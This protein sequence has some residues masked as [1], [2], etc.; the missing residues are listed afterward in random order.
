MISYKKFCQGLDDFDDWHYTVGG[1]MCAAKG[2]G[3][4]C[5][6]DKSEI[7]GRIYGLFINTWFQKPYT[8]RHEGRAYKERLDEIEKNTQGNPDIFAAINLCR[9]VTAEADRLEIYRDI[10]SEYAAMVAEAGSELKK[11][12]EMMGGIKE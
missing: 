5:C 9:E 12:I 6:L 4:K 7:R 10:L 2:E 3:L 1:S 8:E 11:R